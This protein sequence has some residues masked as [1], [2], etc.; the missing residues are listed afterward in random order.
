MTRPRARSVR[1]LHAQ[2]P[3]GRMAGG[4][5]CRLRA[6]GH[7]SSTWGHTVMGTGM[8]SP[9]PQQRYSPAVHGAP[10]MHR[11][12]NQSVGLEGEDR[13][14]VARAQSCR[15]GGEPSHCRPRRWA[16]GTVSAGSGHA[17]GRARAFPEDTG[18]KKERLV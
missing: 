7:R 17:E 12:T 2:W 11:A 14:H 15:C 13:P 4:R 1:P 8:P 3:S 9:P 10:A 18:L 16:E 6:L 5:S